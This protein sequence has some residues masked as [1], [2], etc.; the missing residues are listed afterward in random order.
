MLA[1][2]QPAGAAWIEIGTYISSCPVTASQ[3]AGAAWIEMLTNSYA[4]PTGTGSQPAGAAWIEISYFYETTG[5]AS[6]AAR[7]G[8]VD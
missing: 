8:C 5:N 7:R 3:P 4:F 6:V 1:A 2:S